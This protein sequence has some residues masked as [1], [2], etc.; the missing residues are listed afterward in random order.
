MVA[1]NWDP[2]A[3]MSHPGPS[4]QSRILLRTAFRLLPPLPVWVGLAEDLHGLLTS[5]P[6]NWSPMSPFAPCFPGHGYYKRKNQVLGA[7][8][9]PLLPSFPIK[10]SPYIPAPCVLLHSQLFQQ[11]KN[12]I[13]SLVI[14]GHLCHG[15]S[16]KI[17]LK[18][19]LKER[20]PPSYFPSPPALCE[21]TD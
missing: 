16:S 4:F 14:P 1:V 20:N 17:F 11:E 6:A 19:L 9:P 18:G 3:C 13:F 10:I 21:P 8:A 2:S 7:E 5:G 12:F 15:Y